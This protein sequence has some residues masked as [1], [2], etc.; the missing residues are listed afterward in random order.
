[1]STANSNARAAVLVIVA[2]AAF[3]CND[4]VIKT[5][6]ARVPIGELI[7]VRGL[8]AIL[9]MV[10][11]LPRIGSRIGRPERFTWMR[12]AGEAAVTFAF[13]LALARLPLG[14]TYTLYFAGP[15]LLTAGAALVLGE[16]V[17][18]RR[19]IAVVTGFVGVI[20][21]LGLPSTWQAASMLALGAAF[22]SVGRD[23]AT[24]KIPASVGSGTVAVVTGVCVAV[25]GALTVVAGDWVWLGWSDIGL[26]GVAAL[27]VAGGYT[28]FVMGLRAGELSFVATLRYSGIPMAMLLGFAIWGDLPTP[29][30]L[31]GA[32]LIAGS[33][34]FIVGFARTA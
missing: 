10:A 19:W 22:L 3:C 8:F 5:L 26:C 20:V 32:L 25:T 16:K 4:A 15:I 2:M 11:L 13:L 24:R 12:G 18:R 14:D 17:G 1:M 29:Q 9:L 7:A 33:G 31:A 30:M 21:V 23:L 27:G 6:S 28:A 34:L